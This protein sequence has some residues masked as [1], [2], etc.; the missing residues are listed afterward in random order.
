MGEDHTGTKPGG[1]EL[2]AVEGCV[3]SASPFPSPASRVSSLSLHVWPPSQRKRDA[4]IRHLIDTLV[5]LSI[6]SKRYGVLPLEE[7][8]STALL[9]EEEAF[10]AA[11]AAASG[12]V[13][14]KDDEVEVL[15]IYS[16]EV[17]D[18]MIKSMKERAVSASSHSI[19]GEGASSNLAPDDSSHS[20][21][22]AEVSNLASS[23]GKMVIELCTSTSIPSFTS[24][25]PNHQPDM[26]PTEREE[27]VQGKGESTGG[28]LEGEKVILVP[29]M[30][31]HVPTY[32]G[33]MQDPA[34][35]TATASEP[36]TL[37]QEYQ[38]HSSWT[39]DP[40]RY[41]VFVVVEHTFIVLD[42][43]LI[44]GGYVPGNPHVEAM[45]GD[46]NIYMNNPDDLQKAEIEI[47]IAEP[48]SR[49]KG[50]AKESILMMMAFS[51]E[52]YGIHTFCAKIALKWLEVMLGL[53]TSNEWMQGFV[54]ISYSEVFKEDYSFDNCNFLCGLHLLAILVTLELPIRGIFPI[55]SRQDTKVASLVWHK[56]FQLSSDPAPR[57]SWMTRRAGLCFDHWYQEDKGSPAAENICKQTRRDV[58]GVYTLTLV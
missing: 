41:L 23:M 30:R 54:D 20:D 43:Q 7:A 47:M 10:A 51:G 37:D 57:F 26:P 36:L 29:Y 48:K 1:G 44:Q 18:C 19:D 55:K 6:L 16:K 2:P 40:Q 46:V 15:Q 56:M 17:G 8:S 13:A 21:V 9:I 34:I 5:T 14:S 39:H 24:P 58:P 27:E 22:N 38:V 42:K 52:E 49:Q 4:V 25:N 28:S 45:V 31:E 32:H 35:L 3:A 12:L 11:S 33:W 50:L 53:D